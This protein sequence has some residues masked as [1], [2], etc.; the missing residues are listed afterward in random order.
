MFTL[1]ICIACPIIQIGLL[2]K[3]PPTTQQGAAHQPSPSYVFVLLILA[4]A[5]L[6]WNFIWAA[7]RS[8]SVLMQVLRSMHRRSNSYF[9]PLPGQGNVNV[10]EYPLAGS[11][12]WL[13]ADAIIHLII[14]WY[15][16]NVAP[17]EFGVKLPLWFV[18]SPKYWRHHFCSKPSVTPPPTSSSPSSAPNP[19]AAVEVIGLV[20]MF[21]KNA[22]YE[23]AHDKLAVNGVSFRI[24]EGQ[25]FSFLGHNGAGKT[26]T[27]NLLCGM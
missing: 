16:D 7:M 23:S 20:K 19:S 26:T 3:L 14:A 21:R 13:Y 22:L 2:V 15:L 1:V 27:I 4:R 5:G 25:V 24:D 6:G 10:A 11:I 18:F 12:A 8:S 9:D 17:G